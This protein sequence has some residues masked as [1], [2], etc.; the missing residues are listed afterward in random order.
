MDIKILMLGDVVGT[1]GCDYLASRGRLRQFVRENG[2]SL[3]IA[4]GENSAEGNGIT[5]TSARS[6]YDAGVDVITGGNHTFR[7]KNFHSML[8]DGEML[9][10][11]ANYPFAAPGVGHVTVDVFG[12]RILVINLIGQVYMDNN[13]SSPFEKLERILNEEK[14]RYDAAVV[15]IHAEATSEKLALARYA[16]HLGLSVAAVAGTHTHIQTADA[17]VIDGV[18]YVTDLGMCGSAAGVLGV[19]TEDVIRKFKYPIPVTFRPAEGEEEA[20][21]AV[22]T[23]E[24]PSGRCRSAVGV[25]F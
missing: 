12:Y 9:V 18:G 2:I 10:R 23:V 20:T 3:V 19:M 4:N 1:A 13:V 14:G 17:R 21:G 22:F 25:R 5:P 15:D 16:A 8:D 24:L 7:K 11:P 6:L